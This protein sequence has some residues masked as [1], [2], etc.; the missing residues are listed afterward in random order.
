MKKLMLTLAVIIGLAT[1]AD[2][3]LL[4]KISG[5]GLAKPSYMIGT[6]HVAPLST[7]DSIKGFDEALSS[8]DAVYGEVVMSEMNSP[9]TQQKMMAMAMAPADSML[10]VVL[11][12]EQFKMVD[13]VVQKYTMGQATLAQ[14]AMMK[15]AV[16]A[17]QLAM[18]QSMKAFPGFN[19]A[20]QLD[21]EVQRR[22]EAAGKKIGGLETVEFQLNKLLGDPIATQ[23]EDLV[24]MARKDVGME[25]FA[26]KLADC[27]RA[28][29]LDGM[30]KLMLDP[31][32][33]STEA[34][35]ERLITSR[36]ISWVDELKALMP[37]ES[38]MICV[39]AGHLPGDRGLI[40]LL[41][42]AGFTVEP[43]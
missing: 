13:E 31:E 18:L 12:P 2:A 22:G 20:E 16:V 28:Q 38:V 14:M 26:H 35:M 21:Q 8:A 40:S 10:T 32:M 27:Y 9:E 3:Q 23:A 15:P 5:N 36:N 25:E 39:G 29:D 7:L 11:T 41:R 33:G 43:Y 6:H 42:E 34:E 17:V 24:E 30:Y 4:W 1:G 37:G 19:A